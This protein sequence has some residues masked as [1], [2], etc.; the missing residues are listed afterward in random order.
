MQSPKKKIIIAYCRLVVNIGLG[1]IIKRHI[2]RP[3]ESVAYHEEDHQL[4]FER[5]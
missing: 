5:D 1:I 2:G 3:D 4:Q